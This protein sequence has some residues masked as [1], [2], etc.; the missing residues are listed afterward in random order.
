MDGA[1]PALTM[2]MKLN[3][4]LVEIAALFGTSTISV[5]TR[6]RDQGSRLYTVRRRRMTCKLQGEVIMLLYRSH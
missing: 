2:N 6:G 3:V 4:E 5:S 1:M